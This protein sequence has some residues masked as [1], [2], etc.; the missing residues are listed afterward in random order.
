MK[1]ILS[2]DPDF[3]VTEIFHYDNLT[4]DVHIETVQDVEG[5][6]DHSRELAND[7][8]YT[9]DGIKDG[10]WH[11]A[12]IPIVVQMRWLSE[13]GSKNWP[14]RPGNEKLLFRLLNSPEY[15]YLKT[16]NK[17]HLGK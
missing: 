6:L 7:D 5:H 15:K 10:M 14:M 12:H 13:Y 16:T 4:G 1:R 3:G 17:I 2:H 9:K 11:Y 8:Q